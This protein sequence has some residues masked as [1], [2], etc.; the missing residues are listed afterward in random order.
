MSLKVRDM[1]THVYMY[2]QEGHQCDLSIKPVK[3][4]SMTSRG[5][6]HYHI[7]TQLPK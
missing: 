5:Q 3:E 1:A 2:I 4:V 6:A 7:E